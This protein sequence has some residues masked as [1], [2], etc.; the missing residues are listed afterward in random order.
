MRFLFGLD[1][2]ATLA[3]TPHDSDIDCC[4]W[5]SPEQILSAETL[6]SPLVAESVRLWQ[7]GPAIRCS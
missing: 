3:T 6:R 5:L 1:L 2:P 4:W 7:Q